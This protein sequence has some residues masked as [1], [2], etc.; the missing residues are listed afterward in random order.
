MTG[1]QQEIP[2]IWGEK[3]VGQGEALE[4]AEKR[5]EPVVTKGTAERSVSETQLL[6][7]VL[8]RGNLKR[9]LKRVVS[10]GGAAGIDGMTVTG[11]YPGWQCVGGGSGP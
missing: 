7:K 8:E 4:T 9:A 1:E 2:G 11:A 3:A 6:E 5:A 10:N